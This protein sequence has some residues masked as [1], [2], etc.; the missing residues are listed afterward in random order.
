MA[1]MSS[2]TPAAE[3]TIKM[4]TTDSQGRAMQFEPAFLKVAP[5]DTVTFAASEMHD[6]DSLPD[7]VPQGADGWKG[8]MDEEVRVTLTVEGLY[9]FKCTP[10]FFDGMVGLI[11]VGDAAQ[12]AAAI[13]ALKMSPKARVRMDELLA[14]SAA[15]D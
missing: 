10:H 5:G 4:F 15:S 9:A 8:N 3:F 1:S 11:Q 6:S 7:G 12:N 13:V 2:S 14:E